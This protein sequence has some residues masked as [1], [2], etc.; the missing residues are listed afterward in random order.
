MLKIACSPIYA[1]PLPKGHRFPMIKY[2]LL[3]QQLLHEGT[4]TE[5]NLFKPKTLPE[6]Y[7]I[8]THCPTYWQKLKMLNLSKQEERRTGFPLTAKLDE[9]CRWYTPRFYQ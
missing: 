6:K 5:T 9:Y 3:P 8:N 2:E 1:H 7:I 4:I